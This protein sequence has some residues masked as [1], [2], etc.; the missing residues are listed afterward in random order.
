MKE[1]FPI[2]IKKK[3]KQR[4][5]KKKKKKKIGNIYQVSFYIKA[6]LD[7]IVRLKVEDTTYSKTISFGMQL[8]LG[9]N[10]YLLVSK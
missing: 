4:K 1:H 2:I 6:A 10:I 3:K 9:I 8:K 5:K 7:K